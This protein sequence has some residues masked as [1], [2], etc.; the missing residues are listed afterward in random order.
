M[1]TQSPDADWIAEHRR[2]WEQK[3]SLRAVYE[4]WFTQLHDACVPGAPVVELGCGA[5][6]FKQRYPEVLAT[7]AAMNPYADRIVDASALPFADASVGTYVMLDVFHHLPEPARFLAEAARTLLPGG[8]VVMI[9]PWVGLAGRLLYRYVHHEECD[10]GVDPAAP[11]NRADKD[12]MQGN[13]ALP[14]LY[15]R[16]GGHLGALDVPLRVVRREPFAALPWLLSGGFQP[17]SL[18]APSL[19]TAAH[20]L[21]RMLSTVP[22]L[23][24]TRC[25]L[26]L[27]R[28]S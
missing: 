19:A 10:L 11:W 2:V 7:D 12:H 3:A 22:A 18:L 24:A 13:V 20:A 9:E 16:P 1:L 4:R 27:E 6:L 14:Y 26:I 21:D 25:T 15:F 8:R 28:R 23:T 5:G 17:F